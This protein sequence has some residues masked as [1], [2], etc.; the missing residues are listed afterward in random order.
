MGES[1]SCI[2]LHFVN[3]HFSPPTFINSHLFYAIFKACERSSKYQ[4]I[5]LKIHMQPI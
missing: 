2:L 5:E 4:P 1:P 3:T